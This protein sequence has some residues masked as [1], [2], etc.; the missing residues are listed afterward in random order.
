MTPEEL[1]QF[2][3][4]SGRPL[5]KDQIKYILMQQ[6]EEGEYDDEEYEHEEAPPAKAGMKRND[7]NSSF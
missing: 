7:L 3:D 2:V 4:E 5:S 1:G 6:Q